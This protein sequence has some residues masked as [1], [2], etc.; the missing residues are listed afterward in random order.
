MFSALK[1]GSQ[2]ARP[3]GR[4]D[5]FVWT[6]FIRLCAFIPSKLME[7]FWVKIPW[8]DFSLYLAMMPFLFFIVRGRVK[9]IE[10]GIQEKTI[11][12]ESWVV[13][14][15]ISAVFY[16]RETFMQVEEMDANRAMLTLLLII[17]TLVPFAFLHL[18]LLFKR[19]Y[20]AMEKEA[21]KQ[22]ALSTAKPDNGNVETK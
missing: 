2:V 8:V 10:K 9:D 16:A 4:G 13:F 14:V 20:L 21:A 17:L 22:A 6:F 19:G 12:L 18:Y 7:K 5:Y 11:L 3:L 1:L 15:I